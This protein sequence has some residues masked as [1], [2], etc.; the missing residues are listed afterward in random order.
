MLAVH[1]MNIAFDRSEIR[2]PAGRLVTVV[3]T[4][5]DTGVPHDFGVSIPFVPHTETCS[6]PCE[7]SITFESG[8]P[9]SYTFQ[10][11]IHA[12]MVGAFVVE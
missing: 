10:C 8:A 3:F 7:R 6:G 2:V 1:A 11:S 9:A 4:N 5:S 12:E